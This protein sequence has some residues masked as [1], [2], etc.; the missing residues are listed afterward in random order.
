LNTQAVETDSV[1]NPGV[2]I[3]EYKAEKIAEAMG[4]D[5]LGTFGAQYPVADDDEEN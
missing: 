1:L 3:D 4:V 2:D 5:E